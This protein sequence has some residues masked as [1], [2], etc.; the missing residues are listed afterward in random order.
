[1]ASRI[2]YIDDNG[3]RFQIWDHRDD[4]SGYLQSYTYESPRGDRIRATWSDEAD[5]YVA[6]DPRGPTGG[7][8][9]IHVQGR[10]RAN[11]KEIIAGL[12]ILDQLSGS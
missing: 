12:R 2:F 8:L 9:G 3:R 7:R 11:S 6:S 4:S 5:G 1:M 10:T